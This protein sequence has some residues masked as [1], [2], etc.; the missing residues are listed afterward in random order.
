MERELYFSSTISRFQFACEREM[1]IDRFIFTMHS[2]DPFFKREINRE[3][4]PLFI[5]LLSR[6]HFR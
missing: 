3:S 5:A 2:L 1:L 4:L 6:V